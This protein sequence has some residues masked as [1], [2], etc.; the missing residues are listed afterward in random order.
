[1]RTVLATLLLAAVTGAA[2]AETIQEKGKRVVDEALAALGGQAFL[3]MQDREESG[4]AFSFYHEKLN[5]MSLAHIYTRYLVR[6]EPPEL[7]FIGV[8]ERE[9]FGKKQDDVVLFTDG[10]GYELTFRGARPLPDT[11][12]KLYKDTTLRNIF[13][14]LRQRLGEPGLIFELHGTDFFENHPV[15]IVDITD[16]NNDTVTVYFDQLTKLPVR[17]SFMR[18]DPIN[19]DKIEEVA[20]FARY[21]E[22][23]G[24]IMWPFDIRRERNGDMVFEMN[25][26]E[27]KI[28]QD[29]RDNMFT[30]P[31]GLKILPK[32]K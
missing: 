2:R 31:A 18:R 17:Q 24:G 23:S 6:P 12:V 11:R 1:M 22:V 27:V 16:A 21:R 3:T 19:N 13:Y 29:L 14:I 8:R 15:D 9:A 10:A 7:G 5:G 20:A 30:L 28:N 32:E 25:S 26:E 4:T